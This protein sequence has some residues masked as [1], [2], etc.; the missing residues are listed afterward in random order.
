[1][2]QK[3]LNIPIPLEG[4]ES[5]H[6]DMAR[7]NAAKLTISTAALTYNLLCLGQIPE[8]VIDEKSFDGFMKALIQVDTAESRQYVGRICSIISQIRNDET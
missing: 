1:M 2:N 6:L 8:N 5:N 4:F 3:N 7:Q